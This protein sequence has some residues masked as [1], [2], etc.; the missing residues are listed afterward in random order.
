[1]QKI[2][3]IISLID[4]AIKEDWINTLTSWWIINDWYNDEVVRYRD[5]IKNSKNWL[6]NYQAQLIEKTWISKLKIKYTNAS[7]YFIEVTKSQISQVPDNFIHKQ[8]LVNASRF[9]TSELK[10]FEKDLM[11]AE[12]IL[13]ELEYNIFFRS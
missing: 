11:N 2:L 1:M 5:I 4:S 8:S 13:S 10:D 9:I 3:D 7:W 12:S 6:A